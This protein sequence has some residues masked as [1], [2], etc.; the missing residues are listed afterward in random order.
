MLHP[1]KAFQTEIVTTGTA[2]VKNVMFSPILHHPPAW[3][4]QPNDQDHGQDMYLSFTLIKSLLVKVRV[5]WLV[6]T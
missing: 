6:K 4:I 1:P 5:R 3:I 2:K